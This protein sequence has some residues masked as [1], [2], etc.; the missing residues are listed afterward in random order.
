MCTEDPSPPSLPQSVITLVSG[1]P[2]SQVHRN[3]LVFGTL[4]GAG[5]RVSS[6]LCPVEAALSSVQSRLPPL[7]GVLLSHTHFPC[8]PASQFPPLP[9]SHNESLEQ[10]HQRHTASNHIYPLDTC[11]LSD[12]GLHRTTEV[13]R[14]RLTLNVLILYC[15]CPRSL[16]RRQKV[17]SGS[18]EHWALS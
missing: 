2:L 7:A 5:F 16:E 4:C 11:H 13:E 14:D 17:S 9:T 12:R 18:H 15:P 1:L 6:L 8:F 10:Q 3:Y